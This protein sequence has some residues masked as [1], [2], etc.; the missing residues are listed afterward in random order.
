MFAG[1]HPIRIP[2]MAK[3]QA[4]LNRMI[5]IPFSNAT[6]PEQQTQ[7]LYR[8]LQQEAAYIV[9]QSISAYRDLIQRNFVVT[10]SAIPPEYA[11]E[12]G[13]SQIL[14][15]DAFVS[16]F[17]VLDETGEV[18]TTQLYQVYQDTSYSCNVLSRIEFA[19]TLSDVLSRYTGV[20]AIKRV[21]GQDSRGYKGIC[22][23][24]AVRDHPIA[25]VLL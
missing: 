1:N 9:G 18:S 24:N 22:L 25:N 6:P 11:P 16:S 14:D 5:V 23:K 4:L 3:E 10:R 19:R 2:N 15:V 8:L 13:K 20:T 17:C 7:Q 21:H 12:E